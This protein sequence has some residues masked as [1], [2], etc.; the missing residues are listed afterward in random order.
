[1]EYASTIRT[2]I[3][4]RA[5]RDME[6]YIAELAR[7]RSPTDRQLLDAWEKMLDTGPFP[8]RDAGFYASVR[9]RSDA[10]H[11]D[12]GNERDA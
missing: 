7:Y 10:A 11:A 2:M 3:T 4:D 8:A 5:A 12:V 9:T 1:M 6:R